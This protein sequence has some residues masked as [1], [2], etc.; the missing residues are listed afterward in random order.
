[1]VEPV[2]THGIVSHPGL[3]GDEGIQIRGSVFVKST[4]I[5]IGR[6]YV[7]TD[8]EGY[9]NPSINHSWFR[10][11]GFYVTDFPT[12]CISVFFLRFAR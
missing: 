12:F 1:M 6:V 2:S 4:C 3:P 7:G 10:V 9:I 5:V 11:V 8:P